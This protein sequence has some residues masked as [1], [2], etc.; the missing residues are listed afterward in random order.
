ML[1]IAIAEC[2]AATSRAPCRRSLSSHRALTALMAMTA[3]S[4]A[5]VGECG[6]V[7]TDVAR[8]LTLESSWTESWSA[9]Q[10]GW[11]GVA[12]KRPAGSSNL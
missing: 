6:A 3:F 5:Y 11:T 12:A 8:F 1:R 4:D 10:T 2:F 9:G 7:P